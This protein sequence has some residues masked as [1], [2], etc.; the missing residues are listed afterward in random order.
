MIWSTSA[1]IG[2]EG[3]DLLGAVQIMPDAFW[4]ILNLRVLFKF[5][6]LAFILV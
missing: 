5:N 4:N 6:I 1:R 2:S 3:T